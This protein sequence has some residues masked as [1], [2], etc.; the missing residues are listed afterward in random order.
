MTYQEVGTTAAST[1]QFTLADITQP[2][3]AFDFVVRAVNDAGT[4]DDSPKL[5]VK[6]VDAPSTPL[7]PT[8]LFADGTTI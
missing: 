6:A 7:A 8:S 4:S 5:T 3:T 1:R 2:G